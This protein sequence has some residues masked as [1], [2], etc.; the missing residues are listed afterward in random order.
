MKKLIAFV[1]ALLFLGSCSNDE[2]PKPVT[3]YV[4]GTARETLDGN[5]RAVL[6]ENGAPQFLSPATQEGSANEVLVYSKNVHVVGG[7]TNNNGMSQATYWKNGVAQTLE[8]DA[9]IASYANSICIYNNDVYIA[10]YHNNHAAYWKNGVLQ[11]M[12]S[13]TAT[14]TYGIFVSSNGIHIG[15]W[16]N[17][18]VKLW[19]NGT[20]ITLSDGAVFDRLRDFY[21][22]Q[23]DVYFLVNEEVSGLPSKIKYWKNGVAH[24]IPNA[25]NTL[26][27]SIHV[28]NGKVYVAGMVAAKPKYWVNGKSTDLN[29][30]EM[31]VWSITAFKG[32]VY[33]AGSSNKT[34]K[35][36]K[37]N[38]EMQFANTAFYNDPYDVAVV[39]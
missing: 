29:K 8:V 20:V 12:T 3:V 5:D 22:D 35:I 1:G 38:K 9:S 4:A 28:V 10:G 2:S 33:C 15:L 32:N 27:S 30:E 14:N 13:T 34:L 21:V 16:E 23:G 6:W 18:L 24:Y 37:N 36:W 26:A 39:E 31:Q 7:V 19:K 25:T 11:D 17:N